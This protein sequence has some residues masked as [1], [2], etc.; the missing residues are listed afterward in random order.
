MLTEQQLSDVRRYA[1]YPMLGDTVA[2]DSRDFAYG[3]V[4]PGTW[5]TLQHR[6]THLRPE[7]E[8]TLINY[9]TT[10]TTLESAIPTSGENLDTD[11]AAVWVHNKQEVSD[12]MRLYNL[13][14]REMCAF[15]G[16]VPGPNL[17]RGGSQI[18]R[19]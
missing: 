6:L 17:G 12:R 9:L 4:S 1:G 3:W 13:W 15:I 8:S 11:V 7:E 14:R 5:Q 18:V 19:G 16:I 10:L 2:D